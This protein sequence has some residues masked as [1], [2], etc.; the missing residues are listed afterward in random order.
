MIPV[1][2][3]QHKRR[4][5]Q[6]T[7]STTSTGGWSASSSRLPIALRTSRPSTS[8]ADDADQ[9]PVLV[10]EETQLTNWTIWS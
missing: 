9:P 5:L 3:S 10:V 8:S 6:V 1:Q 4:L 7:S 2:G